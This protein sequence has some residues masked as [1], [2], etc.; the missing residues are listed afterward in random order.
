MIAETLE[1][2]CA[3]ESPEVLEE[4]IASHVGMGYRK[5]GVKV[6][7]F[8]QKTREEI[9][10]QYRD[11]K[12][13]S[14]AANLLEAFEHMG[15]FE[16]QVILRN[17]D[18][19][20]LAAALHGASGKVIVRFLENLSER[21]LP[22]ICREIEQWSGTEEEMTAAQSRMLELGSSCRYGE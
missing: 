3:G 6:E 17:I 5:G 9:L 8:R 18:D 4:L 20:S 2:I 16:I 13:Y 14:K 1:G 7:Q 21:M 15:N 10:E 12:P 19:E 22:I 11:R